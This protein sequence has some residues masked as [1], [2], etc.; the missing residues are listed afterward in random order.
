MSIETHL[1]QLKAK[2]RALSD[3]IE[4][5]QRSPASDDLQIRALKRQ[6][7]QIKEEITRLQAH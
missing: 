2:H 5:E 1:E 3:R 4:I 6:K 7:L